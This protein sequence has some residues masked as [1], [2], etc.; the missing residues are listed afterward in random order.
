M[1]IVDNYKEIL[2]EAAIVLTLLMLLI[3]GVGFMALIPLKSRVDSLRNTVELYKSGA[4][5]EEDLVIKLARVKSS[6]EDRFTP[7]FALTK[8]D[9]D[10]ISEAREIVKKSRGVDVS[11]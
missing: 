5:S 11:W 10:I 9:H 3:C 1:N 7:C 8:S 2:V 4:S 6:M